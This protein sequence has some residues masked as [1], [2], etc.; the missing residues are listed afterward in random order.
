MVAEGYIYAGG[1]VLFFCVWLVLG[2]VYGISRDKQLAYELQ[3]KL[4]Q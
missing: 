3:Y 2:V 1:N 4:Y